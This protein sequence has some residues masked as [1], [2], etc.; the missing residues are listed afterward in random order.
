MTNQWLKPGNFNELP[1]ADPHAG[2]CGGRGRKTPG[3]PIMCQ[4]HQKYSD[5]S[6]IR[7]WIDPFLKDSIIREGTSNFQRCHRTDRFCT[8]KLKKKRKAANIAIFLDMIAANR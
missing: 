6:T 1:V 4:P 2:W 8:G 3:F 7:R 5:L